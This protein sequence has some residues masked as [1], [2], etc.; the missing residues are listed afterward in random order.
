MYS[1]Y[2]NDKKYR[3][4]MI[5]HSIALFSRVADINKKLQHPNKS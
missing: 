1:I 5:L 2:C 3:I 4:N